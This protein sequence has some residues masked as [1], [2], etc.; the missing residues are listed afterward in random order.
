M[1]DK[2]HGSRVKVLAFGMAAE[3]MKTSG[4]I[5]EGLRDSDQ[6]RAWLDTQYPGLKGMNLTIAVNKKMIYSNTILADGNEVALLP[7]FA[8]G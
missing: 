2:L 3:Q 1:E 7:P 8:G 4:I 6:L 5:V